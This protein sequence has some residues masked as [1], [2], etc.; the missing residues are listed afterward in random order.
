MDRAIF[1]NLLRCMA[2]EENKL[3]EQSPE[4]LMMIGEF[5]ESI[6]EAHDFYPVF[7]TEREYRIMHDARMLGT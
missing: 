1:A 4:G 5:G 3:I 7:A 6:T 2:S